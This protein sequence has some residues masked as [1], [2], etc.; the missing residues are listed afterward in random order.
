MKLKMGKK[1][2]SV[3]LDED[4]LKEFKKKIGP[5]RLSKALNSFLETVVG[6]KKKR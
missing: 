2:V 6:V 3:N 1:I 4:L 5:Q